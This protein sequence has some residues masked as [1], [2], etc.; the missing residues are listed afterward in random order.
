MC[1]RITTIEIHLNELSDA[2]NL[3]RFQVVGNCFVSVSEADSS[4]ADMAIL[5][6]NELLDSSW[7]SKTIAHRDDFL[8]FRTDDE[9]K[10]NTCSVFTRES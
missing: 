5:I 2:K 3:Q 1:H 7:Y 9:K 8:I 6:E 10:K 4:V